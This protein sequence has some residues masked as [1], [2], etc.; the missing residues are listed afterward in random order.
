MALKKE[1]KKKKNSAFAF[2]TITKQNL[3]TTVTEK[4]K[5]KIEE[6]NTVLVLQTKKDFTLFLSLSLSSNI[7]RFINWLQK[8]TYLV[9]ICLS[10]AHLGQFCFIDCMVKIQSFL[11]W[12]LIRVTLCVWAWMDLLRLKLMIL[13]RVWEVFGEWM[14]Y[15]IGIRWWVYESMIKSI[16]HQEERRKPSWRI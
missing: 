5:N 10:K 9:F 1:R 7:A 4:I 12:I 8:F 14:R 2:A 15:G 3:K 6:R 13:M 16:H 11:G